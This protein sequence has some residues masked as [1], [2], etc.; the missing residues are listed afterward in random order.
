MSEEEAFAL[1]LSVADA[2]PA[3]L[4]SLP[5]SPPSRAR[6]HGRGSFPA[7]PPPPHARDHDCGSI[8]ASNGAE[9]GA[10]GAEA[11]SGEP[12]GMSEEEELAFALA[13]S[14]EEADAFAASEAEGVQAAAGGGGRGVAA[15]VRGGGAAAVSRGASDTAGGADRIDR[16][17]EPPHPTSPSLPPRG[18]AAPP[19]EDEQLA[20]ALSASLADPSFVFVQ[21]EDAAPGGNGLPGTAWA[22]GGAGVLG[23]PPAG[24]RVSVLGAWEVPCGEGR[25]DTYMEYQLQVVFPPS[26]AHGAVTCAQRFSSFVD[27][28]GRLGR[29]APG[30]RISREAR[31]CVDRWRSRL[32]VE[33]RHTRSK[34]PAVVTARVAMLQRMMDE[35][36]AFPDV[37]ESTALASFLM[38]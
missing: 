33:K 26:E 10:V 36:V 6:E 32:T 15:G 3:R 24:L 12:R 9:P 23:G 11:S 27:L 20:W 28:L 31:A 38:A 7:S 29:E 37:C 14:R 30:E 1:A 19:T 16:L 25:R 4:D 35:L 2:P 8:F 17:A 18:A 21:G 13:L 22:A 34:A 5:A